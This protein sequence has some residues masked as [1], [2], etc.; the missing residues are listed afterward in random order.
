[1]LYRRGQIVME[2]RPGP[3]LQT[4]GDRQDAFRESP[5]PDQ[6]GHAAV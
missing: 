1:M 4:G 2:Q 6:F 5:L 3:V